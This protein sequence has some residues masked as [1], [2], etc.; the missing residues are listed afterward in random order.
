MAEIER[1]IIQTSVEDTIR[2]LEDCP[3]KGFIVPQ[4][5]LVQV[6]NRVSIAHLSI[7]RAMKF[8]IRESGGTFEEIHGLGKLYQQLAQNDPVS[9]GALDSAFQ[10][11]VRHYRFNPNATDMRHFKT[12]AQ[13]LETVGSDQAFQNVRYWELN[14]SLEE[15]LLRK[16]FPNIHLEL[17]H[18]LSEILI[19]HRRPME[20]VV[21]RVERIIKDAILQFGD[22]WYESE[23]IREYP[24]GSYNHWLTR[25]RNFKD[26]LLEAVKEGLE[27]GNAYACK[28]MRTAHEQLLESKDPAVQYFVNSLDVLL[29]QPRDAIPKAEW[30]DPKERRKGRVCTPGGSN[31]GFVEKYVDGLWYITRLEG[32]PP[33]PP[34]KAMTQIDALCYLAA[35]MTRPAQVTTDGEERTLRIVE[36]F[37]SDFRRARIKVDPRDPVMNKVTFW[38]N[39]HG[40]EVGQQ[41]RIESGRT[42][43]EFFSD[44][45]EGEVVAVGGSEVSILGW[46]VV[47]IGGENVSDQHHDHSH[48]L[49]SVEQ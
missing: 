34:A 2:I 36:G 18:G 24:V 32:G 27:I 11:A 37:H 44:K 7:E 13:Y 31:L 14:L 43:T 10:A 12:V 30:L 21:D 19:S 25:H 20:T 8:L 45:I 9:A 6:M 49:E 22:R 48:S 17:L 28:S 46:H 3:V 41:I 38:D 35:T 33:K 16:I 5:T 4:I 15:I 47:V 39:D 40:L 23:S 42:D 26:A 1:D 29:T